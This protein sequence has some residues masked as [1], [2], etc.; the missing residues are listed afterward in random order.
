MERQYIKN[1]PPENKSIETIARHWLIAP[2][3]RKNQ[4]RQIYQRVRCTLFEEK[5]SL[6]L[7][8]LLL[9]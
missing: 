3:Q 4:G 6:S 8:S 5:Y 1:I 7:N 2:L 9:R